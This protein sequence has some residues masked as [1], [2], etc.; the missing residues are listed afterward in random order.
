MINGTRCSS[1]SR[2][3]STACPRSCA[4]PAGCSRSARSSSPRSGARATRSSTPPARGP[5]AWCSAPRSCGPPSTRARRSSTTAEAEARRLRHEAEDY[6]DQKL[7]QLRDR[8]RHATLKTVQAGRERAARSPPRPADARRRRCRGR[9]R[10]DEAG[11]LRP[12]RLTCRRPP[13]RSVVGVADLLRRP[14]VAT[15]RQRLEVPRSTALRSST[16]A[17]ARRCDGRRRRRARVARTTASSSTGTVR[18]RGRASAGAASDR[19]AAS[20]SVEVSEVFEP[21][22][23]SRAR[24]TRSTATRSTSSRW[25]R[26]AVAARAAAGAAVR[27]RTARACAPTLRRR[28]RTPG[29]LRVRTEPSATPGG[30]PSTCCASCGHDRRPGRFDRWPRS[31]RYPATGPTDGQDHDGR[32]QEEDLQGQEPQPAGLGLDARRA[33]PQHLPALRRRQA[34]HVVCGNCGWYDG[35]Q[36][37]DVD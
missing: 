7:A 17:G 10:V 11:V 37:I 26:D 12:G 19:P 18:R 22:P 33:G 15:A 34:P 24:P 13:G 32:P 23:A 1:C 14:G 30:R 35:R 29:R 36:A 25:S 4:P 3:R 16:S 31:A 27:R 5:S 20:S 28:A 8:A 6:C 21:R 2:R 9:R